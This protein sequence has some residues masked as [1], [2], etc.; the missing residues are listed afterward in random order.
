[1]EILISLG[2]LTST[3]VLVAELATWSMAERT[4]VGERIAAI[5]TTANILEAARGRPWADLTPE[6]AAAQ[7]LPDELRTRLRGVTL[8]VRVEPEPDRPR[9][10]RVTVGITWRHADGAQARSVITKALFADRSA[11][12]GS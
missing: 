10:K 4:R 8:S 9:V 1:M 6:W 11:G 5:E 2:V 7:Q 12:G 3:M